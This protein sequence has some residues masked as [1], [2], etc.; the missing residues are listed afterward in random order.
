M[1]ACVSLYSVVPSQRIFASS[2]L[3]SS[4]QSRAVRFYLL[5]PLLR[6]KGKFREV[7]V[8][9]DDGCDILRH[10]FHGFKKLALHRRNTYHGLETA[11]LW[12]SSQQ[13]S[14]NNKQDNRERHFFHSFTLRDFNNK[15][16]LFTYSSFIFIKRNAIPRFAYL[17]V[18]FCALGPA[19]TDF[20]IR[21]ISLFL[22]TLYCA[23]IRKTI[24]VLGG[25]GP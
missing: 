7:V 5:I 3:S 21:K 25:N 16:R 1:A 23:K 22:F 14:A 9:D 18:L 11:V 15:K 12:T 13:T 10:D 24:T 19:K 17:L 6:W 2:M 4:F 20:R 8:Q